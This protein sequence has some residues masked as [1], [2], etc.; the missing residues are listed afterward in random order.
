[1][2]SIIV[3]KSQE[4]EE[5]VLGTGRAEYGDGTRDINGRD[6]RPGA[7]DRA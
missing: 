5:R 1:M 6:E 4:G 3:K 2:P 7:E